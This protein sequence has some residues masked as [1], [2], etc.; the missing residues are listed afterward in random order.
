MINSEDV[1]IR[2][3]GPGSLVTWLTRAVSG[4]GVMGGEIVE[5]RGERREELHAIQFREL[6]C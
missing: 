6:V 3:F 4:R 2:I 1:R 5:A